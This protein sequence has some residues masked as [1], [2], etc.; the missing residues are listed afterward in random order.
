MFFLNYL[1]GIEKLGLEFFVSDPKARLPTVTTIKVPVG[2][3]WK[4]VTGIA[5]LK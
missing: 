2:I 5:I 1:T 3:D 4:A